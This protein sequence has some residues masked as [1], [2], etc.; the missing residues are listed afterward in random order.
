MKR[1]P[2]AAIMHAVEDLFRSGL[3]AF[4]MQ[5]SHP[6][7]KGTATEDRWID[8]FSNRLPKKYKVGRAFV[9]DS[10]GGTSA[11]I[12]CVIY[13]AVHT[14]ALYGE[15]ETLHIPAEAVYAVFEIKQEFMKQEIEYASDKVKSVRNLHRQYAPITDRGKQ[16]PPRRPHEIVGGLLIGR[17]GVSPETA[18]EHFS[19][20][21]LDV[22]LSAGESADAVCI[23]R[24]DSGKIQ[25]NS[26]KGALIAG[27]F[28]LQSKLQEMGTVGAIDFSSYERSAMDDA[29][30]QGKEISRIRGFGLDGEEVDAF[31]LA[32]DNCASDFNLL[33]DYDRKSIVSPQTDPVIRHVKLEIDDKPEIDDDVSILSDIE[34]YRLTASKAEALVQAIR[35]EHGK[36]SLFGRET[37]PGKFAGIVDSV[38]QQ[39]I[40]GQDAYLSFWSKAAHLLYFIVRG[41]PFVDGNKR[42][43]AFLFCW[44]MDMEDPEVRSRTIG[45]HG[46]WAVTLLVAVSRPEDKDLL[47]KLIERLVAES[48]D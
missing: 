10:E 46:I 43:A 31:L 20:S 34:P 18:R 24:F 7:A 25:Y 17:L 6:G 14:P 39:T 42:I 22:V 1:S 36:A 29:D 28:R 15:K 27:L 41:H 23:D 33:D 26:G 19:E 38:F 16:Y 9:V 35:Y 40:S 4:K 12:D 3:K 32:R 8:L 44:L 48:A 13:D 45:S 37:Q 47:I 5:T 30:K 2:L 21:L 11:Q